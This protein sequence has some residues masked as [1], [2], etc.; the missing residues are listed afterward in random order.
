VDDGEAVWLL[1]KFAA[2][3]QAGG[4][5]SLPRSTI[6]SKTPRARFVADWINGDVLPI[7]ADHAR[8][9]WMIESRR[10]KSAPTQPF[11]HRRAKDDVWDNCGFS[12]DRD[13][14]VAASGFCS[15]CGQVGMDVTDDKCAR[16]SAEAKRTAKALAPTRHRD[17][18]VVIGYTF[19][20]CSRCGVRIELRG[21]SVESALCPACEYSR[22]NGVARI[23]CGVLV[24]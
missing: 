18:G 1:P 17:L 11:E 20:P 5:L 2:Q 9:L 21:R 22:A 19:G 14:L 13:N 10:P 3:R 16:C 23:H 6:L 8:T 12:G 7:S 4:S 15:S 24:P